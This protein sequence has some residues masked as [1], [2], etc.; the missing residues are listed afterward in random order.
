MKTY[1]DCIP[2]MM[3]QALRVGRIATTDEKKIKKLLDVVGERIKY[4]PMENT[5]PEMGNFIYKE[6]RKIMGVNDPYKKIKDSNINEVKILYPELKEIINNSDN[7]LFTA[8]KLAIA[9]NII[10]L[11]MNKNFNISSHFPQI[12]AKDFAIN[13]F[14]EFIKHYEKANSILYIGDNA[15]ESVFDKIL[16]EELLIPVTYVVRDIPVLNDVTIDD[17][18]NS[19]IEEVAEIIS[20]GTTAPG[21]ILSLCNENFIEKFYNADMIISKGQG[22][23]EGLSNVKRSVFFLLEAKCPIIAK[24]LNV[25]ENDIVLKFINGNI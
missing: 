9:G 3:D 25:K 2:C 12:L 10:D 4:I 22:N 8:I 23:Y 18:I 7:R 6:V 15:G 16:I 17:A 20:S 5:P 24:D 1:L 13:D 14:D 11:G 19:G 21:T